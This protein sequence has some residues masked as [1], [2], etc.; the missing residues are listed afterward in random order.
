MI[1]MMPLGSELC[2]QEHVLE[3]TV[4]EQEKWRYSFSYSYHVFCSIDMNVHLWFE[5]VFWLCYG[6]IWRRNWE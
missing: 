1:V 2:R 5:R 3:N 6:S 4:L